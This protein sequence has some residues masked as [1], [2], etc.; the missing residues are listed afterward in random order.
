MSYEPKNVVCQ[1]CKA[2]FTIEPDDFGFYEKIKVPPPTFCPECRLI[3]RLAWRNERS[4]HKRKCALCGNSTI[5]VYSE[6]SPIVVYCNE[7]WWSDKWDAMDYGVDFDESRPFLEQLFDLMHKVP[8]VSRF[9]LYTSLVNSEYTNMVGYLKNCYLVTHSDYN[10]DCAYG[11]NLTNSKDCIDTYFVHKSENCYEITNTHK[12]YNTMF[13]VDCMH[14]YNLLFCKNC[15]GCSDC[16]GCVNLVNKKYHIFNEPYTKEEYEEK[17]KE[18]YPSTHEKIKIA[19]KRAQ[20]V[21]IKYPQKYMHGI[22]NKDVSGDYIFNCKNVKDSYF[23]GKLDDSRYCMLITPEESRSSHCYDFTHFGVNSELLYESLMSGWSSR[24][25]F[26]WF[27]TISGQDIEYSMW[28]LDNKNLFGCVGVKKKQYCILNKKYS[29]ERYEELREKII[30]HM[31]DMPYID[32]KGRIYKYG[33]FFPMEASP[34]GYNETAHIYFPL[35]KEQVFERGYVWREPDERSY[36]INEETKAC[37][38]EGKCMHNCSL[39]FRFI[40]SE[41][42][43]YKKHDLPP[44]KLCFNCRHANRVSQT[45]SPKFWHRTCMCDKT[46][47]HHAGKCEVEFETSYAPE[48]PEIIYCEKCYQQEVY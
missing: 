24:L 16:F 28:C 42:Q 1:N 36:A 4:L 19:W 27:V 44:P 7:C 21:W 32:E 11:S 13:S 31:Q 25:K 3:R 5:A 9:G 46:H 35:T 23:C 37:E 33:E 14:C 47:A 26:S 30:K 43:F 20:E 22:K 18:L 29:K 41:L 34:F 48:R 17:L 45:N 8:A 40:P 12:S 39:A 15:T 10:E 2:D 38:H 6:Q